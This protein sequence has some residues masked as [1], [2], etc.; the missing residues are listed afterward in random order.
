[1]HILEASINDV[2]LVVL[3]TTTIIIFMPSTHGNL[4]MKL[5]PKVFLEYVVV[6]TDMSFSTIILSY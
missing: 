1:M 6:A 3:S 5:K 2:Y 4:T